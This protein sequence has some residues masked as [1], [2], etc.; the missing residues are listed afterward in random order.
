MGQVGSAFEGRNYVIAQGLEAY[1]HELLEYLGEQTDLEPGF[2]ERGYG[3]LTVS[4]LSAACGSSAPEAVALP[5][6]DGRERRWVL[7]TL[8]CLRRCLPQALDARRQVLRL[9]K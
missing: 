4:A 6:D 2:W 8:M 5:W 7:A 3:A 9:S 1:C